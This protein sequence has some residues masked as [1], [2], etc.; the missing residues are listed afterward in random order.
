MEPQSSHLIISAIVSG[1]AVLLTSKVVP[2]FEIRGFFTAVLAAVLIAVMSYLLWWVLFVL[3]LPI[4]I[5]TFG[6][7]TF[8][9]NGVILKICAAMLPGFEL[10][11]WFSA[12]FGSIVLTIISVVLHYILI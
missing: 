12:I 9:I 11:S 10:R 7:F 3:T 2:G 4:N 5:I 1:L 8:V 6:L